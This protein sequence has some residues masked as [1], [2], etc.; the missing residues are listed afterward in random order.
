[1]RILIIENLRAGLGEGGLYDVV[2]ELGR[3]GAE[4]TMRFLTDESGDL[5]TLLADATSFDRVIA[6]G[7]DGTISAI[8]Y[9]LRNTGV[10]IVPYPAG[11]ANLLAANLRMPWDPLQVAELTMRGTPVR[12]DLGELRCD[13]A[14]F[15]GGSKTTGFVIMAGAGFDATIMA[16]AAE[17]KQSL[18]VGAYF[19]SVFGNLTPTHAHFRLTLDD[20][21]V[22]TEGIAVILV[23]FARI[24]FDLAV[25]HNSDAQ[26][27]LLEVVVVRSKTVAGL[28][29]AVWA[30]LLD[31][32]WEHA[33]RSP[34]LEIHSAR[35]IRIESDP[36][37]PIQFDGEPAGAMTPIEAVV[38]PAAA[39]IVAP[40][41]SS[42]RPNDEY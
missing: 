29:P 41:E 37:L 16:G 42:V 10:P 18:G 21:V 24:Q 25:T 13:S 14:C 40:S 35:R 28:L 1:M 6:A 33:D 38:L 32:I 39:T 26:D 4:V 8:T 3:R 27:G 19:L 2:R 12:V 30:A 7:G 31:R 5:Q 20:E 22:E 23:N 34:S 9:H 15:A 11:T 17:L 36:P